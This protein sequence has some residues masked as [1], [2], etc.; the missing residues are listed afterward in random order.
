MKDKKYTK[1]LKSRAPTDWKIILHVEMQQTI[2][3]V[4]RK[5]SIT[6]RF[7]HIFLG[8]LIFKILKKLVI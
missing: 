3:L 2:K 6:L 8:S 1:F 5:N 4:E 7:F